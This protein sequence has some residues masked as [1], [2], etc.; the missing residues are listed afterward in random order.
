MRKRI[1]QT[2]SLH[3]RLNERARE[4]RDR[5]RNLFP[6]AER[7]RLLR[8]A[9]QAEEAAQLNLWVTSPGLVPPA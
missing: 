7:E 4:L 9:H 6:G 2:T 5:A 1:K 8:M 3:E